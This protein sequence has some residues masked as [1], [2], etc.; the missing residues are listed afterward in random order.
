[1]NTGTDGTAATLT[2]WRSRGPHADGKEK[3]AIWDLDRYL[4]DIVGQACLNS[5]ASLTALATREAHSIGRRLD[6]YVETNY[7]LPDA[8]TAS[9]MRAAWVDLAAIVNI[10]DETLPGRIAELLA[11]Y[12]EHSPK[13]IDSPE[14]LARVA[15]LGER[16]AVAGPVPVEA[17]EEL[18]EIIPS[19][20]T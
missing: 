13:N 6:A 15:A 8:R 7:A 11:E 4:C 19:L 9:D 1:M 12:A 2:M 14:F 18:A 3:P 10:V 16:F 5:V 20:W 17:W